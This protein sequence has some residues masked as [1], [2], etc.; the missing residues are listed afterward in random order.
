MCSVQMRE[1]FHTGRSAPDLPDHARNFMGIYYMAK[2]QSDR[3]KGAPQ[4]NPTFASRSTGGASA[5]SSSPTQNT[6]PTA[7]TSLG[8]TTGSKS[9]LGGIPRRSGAGR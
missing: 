5:R 8:A 3:K 9:N 7:T 2:R 1:D 4:P 6:G